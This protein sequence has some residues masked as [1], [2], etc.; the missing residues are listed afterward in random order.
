MRKFGKIIIILV[1]LVAVGGITYYA[2]EKHSEHRVAQTTKSNKVKKSSSSSSK[3]SSSSSMVS[4]ELRQNTVTQS[5]AQ[6][7]DGVAHPNEGIDINKA[8]GVPQHAHLTQEQIEQ[9]YQTFHR[10]TGGDR[11]EY[12]N[13][14]IENG[15]YPDGTLVK[16]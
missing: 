2:G 9:N 3:K 15:Y 11:M 5:N 4:S 10:N 12:A 16:K 8:E 7:T 1:G 14:C 13:N 6:Q